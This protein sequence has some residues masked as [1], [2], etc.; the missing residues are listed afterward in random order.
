MYDDKEFYVKLLNTIFKNRTNWA[1]I[2]VT[3]I[4]LITFGVM[5]ITAQDPSDRLFSI[6]GLIC[7]FIVV[8]GRIFQILRKRSIQENLGVEEPPVYQDIP[9]HQGNVN[10]QKPSPIKELSLENNISISQEV[11]FQPIKESLLETSR[12]KQPIA[13]P[14]GVNSRNFLKLLIT[15]LFIFLL[16][17]LLAYLLG[18]ETLINQFVQNLWEATPSDTTYILSMTNPLWFQIICLLPCTIMLF[19]PIA[20]IFLFV[21]GRITKFDKPIISIL[22]A[23]LSFIL[24]IILYAPFQVLFALI[25]AF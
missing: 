7:I 23:F 2:F 19:L 16:G 15:N 24:G 11:S 3:L 4:L 17:Y 22:S 6:L 12:D 25:A 14:V 8:I 18:S 5:F 10:D 20:S 9:Q 21:L 13:K 1:F